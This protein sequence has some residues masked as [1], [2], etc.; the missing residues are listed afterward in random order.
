VIILFFVTTFPIGIHLFPII[1][2]LVSMFPGE[3]GLMKTKTQAPSFHP[4]RV[5]FT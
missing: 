1:L 3:A 5:D 4:Q 2:K